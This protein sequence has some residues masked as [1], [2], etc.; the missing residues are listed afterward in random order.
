MNQVTV[1]AVCTVFAILLCAQTSNASPFKKRALS[2]SRCFGDTMT[3][4]SRYCYGSMIK[5]SSA[6]K[7][8]L[9][10]ILDK[11]QGLTGEDSPICL[12]AIHIKDM[13]V[14]LAQAFSMIE[15][16]EDINGMEGN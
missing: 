4:L 9:N 8:E 3:T 16:K 13:E 10:Q 2:T 6:G 5:K 12:L 1:V 11:C 7:S 14:R 15:D